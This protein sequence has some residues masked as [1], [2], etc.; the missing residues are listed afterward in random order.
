[1]SDAIL[2]L[3]A[4]SSSFKVTEYLLGEGDVLET[5][6]SGNLDDRAAYAVLGEGGRPVPLKDDRAAI[7]W[8]AVAIILRADKDSPELGGHIT[9]IQSAGPYRDVGET[10]GV[11]RSSE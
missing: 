8:N 10:I 6:I 1:M 7:R 2:V 5:G 3:N 4:G 9:S 11:L